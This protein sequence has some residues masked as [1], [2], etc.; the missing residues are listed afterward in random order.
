MSSRGQVR[1]RLA[2]CGEYHSLEMDRR[3]EFC[4]SGNQNDQLLRKID[5]L[6]EAIYSISGLPPRRQYTEPIVP[7]PTVVDRPVVQRRTS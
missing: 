2:P 7:K 4:N 6:I 5:E 1:L 3:C